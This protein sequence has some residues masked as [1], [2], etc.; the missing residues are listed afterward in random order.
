M[1]DGQRFVN[2]TD[3]IRIAVALFICL[4]IGMPVILAA[5]KN[6]PTE[7][8]SP[9]TNITI[10]GKFN[11]WSNVRSYT[12]PPNDTHNTQPRGIADEP[13]PVEH[14]DVDLL[15]YRVAHDA[16]AICFYMRSGGRIG[17]TQVADEALEKRAGRYYVSV[18]ID[19]DQSDETGYWLNEGGY[20]PTSN[21]YDVN[22][23][24]EFHNGQLNVAK[25]LNHGV[26]SRRAR[27]RAFR[28]QS[29]GQFRRRKRGP[30]PAGFMRLGPSVYDFY[31]EWVYHADDTLTFVRDKGPALGLGIASFSLSADSHK[32][33]MRFPLKGFLKD[34][35]GQPIIGAD[36]VLDISCSLEASGESVPA[37][38]WASDTG[39]PITKYRM[40]S[41]QR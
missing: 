35:K 25:Y 34:E 18:T 4:S 9:P 21:G 3:A 24:L 32:I 29:N 30:Y 22:A 15:E 16:T 27:R 31:T 33:E 37:Q 14:A 28:D 6:E 1:S 2:S 26:S 23:E 7:P 8:D 5:E 36:S 10:D 40:T 41:A 13:I 20:H 11:D 38:R 17:H 12:D 19:V 39:E